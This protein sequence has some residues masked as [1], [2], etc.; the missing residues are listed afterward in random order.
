MRRMSGNWTA[1]V[2]NYNGDTFLDACLIALQGV[3]LKPAAVIVVDNASTDD[4]LLE[5]NGFPWANVFAQRENLGYAGGANAGLAAVETDYAVILNPDVELDPDFGRALVATFDA[6]PRLGAAGALLLYPD[7]RTIQHAGGTV[8]RP[9]LFADHLG[10]GEPLSAEY[11]LERAIDFATGAALCLRMEAVREIGGFDEQFTPAYYEDVDICTRL[12]E[13]GWEVRFAPALRGLHYEGVTLGKSTAY[14]NHIHRNR[15]RY[16]L[17]HLSPDAWRNEF[18]PAEVARLRHELKVAGGEGWPASTGAGAVDMLLRA[19]GDRH[20]WQRPSVLSDSAFPSAQPATD[21]LHPLLGQAPPFAPGNRSLL[22]RICGL[23]NLLPRWYLG[24]ALRGQQ[25]LNEALVRN[26]IDQQQLNLQQDRFNREQ[27]ASILLYA[28][29][30][31]DRLANY[32]PREPE[33]PE[34]QQ[35]DV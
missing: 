16:A 14:Y 5:L 26:L 30:T 7:G 18:V 17:K 9:S 28:L 31:L 15:L 20:D 4:S 35:F 22:G 13:R 10:R 11:E 6:R 1:I 27:T 33:I 29:T 21:E 32:E 25:A 24:R 23:I 2:V 3:R 12:K 19:T 34:P 8:A